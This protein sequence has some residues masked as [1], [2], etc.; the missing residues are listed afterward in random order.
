[1]RWERA[2][3]TGLI[4]SSVSFHPRSAG[5]GFR[6]G[7]EY[8]AIGRTRKEYE[9]DGGFTLKIEMWYMTSPNDQLTVRC[10]NQEQDTKL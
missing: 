5:V 9:F 4:M 7:A 1:M 2:R 6:E 3:I 10:N 8:P